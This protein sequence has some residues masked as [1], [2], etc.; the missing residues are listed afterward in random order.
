[1]QLV[2]NNIAQAPPST[3]RRAAPSSAR[4]SEM[5]SRFQRQRYDS[6]RM[7]RSAAACFDKVD[8]QPTIPSRGGRS[9]R[10]SICLIE[11]SAGHSTYLLSDFHREGPDVRRAL[12]PEGHG[13]RR[14]R[15]RD[16][17]HL[18]TVYSKKHKIR[19]HLVRCLQSSP[20]TARSPT[21]RPRCPDRSALE[22]RV[23]AQGQLVV[24]MLGP[25]AV[26]DFA[27]VER[28]RLR[29]R[30]S[31]VSTHRCT[32]DRQLALIGAAVHTWTVVRLQLP[33]PGLES[34]SVLAAHAGS[35]VCA[36]EHVAVRSGL[37]TVRVGE[38]R[39]RGANALAA[40]GEPGAFRREDRGLTRLPDL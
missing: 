32:R 33:D 6:M 23:D 20:A 38:R 10:R 28:P 12:L 4:G 1:M 14:D 5:E 3:T 31:L 35:R 36:D 13:G 29:A 15:G 8:G 37:D 39:S 27:N 2:H 9:A 11:R 7:R 18:K 25:P 17:D 22:Q 34:P 21:S 30:R 26:S 24:A 40:P 16:A 19:A